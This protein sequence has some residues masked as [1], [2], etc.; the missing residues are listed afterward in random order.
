MDISP[1]PLKEEL[2][3]YLFR[4]ELGHP[5]SVGDQLHAILSNEKIFGVDLYKIGMGSKIEGF[6]KQLIKGPGS[7]RETL[8]QVIVNDNNKVGN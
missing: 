7:I 5:E 3:N 6:F 8:H 4:V 1:D 2:Q